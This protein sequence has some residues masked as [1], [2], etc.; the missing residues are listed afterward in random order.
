ERLAALL[1]RHGIVE[2]ANTDQPV[3]CAGQATLV[4]AGDF[5]DKGPSSLACID[6]LRAL[7]SAAERQGGRVVV[8]MGNHEA[9]FL[10]DPRNRKAEGPWGINREIVA[11]GQTP[12]AVARGD[13]G[14]GAWLRALPFGARV[15]RWFFSHAGDTHGRDVS[16]LE[17]ALRADVDAHDFKGEEV[18]G[19]ASLLCSRLWYEADAALASRFATALG[20]DH[21]GFG[22]DPKA[23]GPRGRIAIGPGR[24]LVRIDCG[25]SR[26]VD[27]SRGGLL[28]VRNVAGAEVIEACYADGTVTRL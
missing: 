1:A 18:V 6:F 27:D 26:R 22:H 13:D 15:G 10:A 19:K 21:I 5:I 11:A 14:R 8:L 4:V 3:W 7:Q 9:E 24:T 2:T 23:L 12:E 25:M 20:V 16:A 28:R 17:K